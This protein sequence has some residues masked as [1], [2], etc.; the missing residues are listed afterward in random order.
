MV[1]WYLWTLTALDPVMQR[2][3]GHGGTRVR[4][5]LLLLTGH[6][7]VHSVDNHSRH[8]GA[9]ASEHIGT[10]S[11]LLRTALWSSAG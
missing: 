10:R 7:R 2:S 6:G 4:L 1:V 5:G 3:C 11:R 9:M 8:R